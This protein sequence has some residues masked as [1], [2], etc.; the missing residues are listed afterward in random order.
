[1]KSI[2][3]SFEA[4]FVICNQVSYLCVFAKSKFVMTSLAFADVATRDE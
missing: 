3:S 4:L 2:D 1:M